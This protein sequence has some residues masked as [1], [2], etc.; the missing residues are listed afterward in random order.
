[1]LIDVLAKRLFGV[2][3]FIKE[4][5]DNKIEI[6]KKDITGQYNFKITLD[7]KGNIYDI[8]KRHIAGTIAKSKD[9]NPNGDLI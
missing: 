4:A 8:E 2:D 6:I 9:D 5:G 1:M 3:A 7:Y